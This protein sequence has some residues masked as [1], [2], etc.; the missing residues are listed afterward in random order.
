MAQYTRLKYKNL[1]VSQHFLLVISY[2]LF[3]FPRAG[4]MGE[5]RPDFPVETTLLQDILRSPRR[6]HGNRHI[7]HPFH[8]S[9]QKRSMADMVKI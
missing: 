7:S 6:L 2:A 5:I 1:V 3:N 8:G 9:H 4:N